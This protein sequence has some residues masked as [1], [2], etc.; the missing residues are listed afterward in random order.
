MKYHIDLLYINGPGVLGI[1]KAVSTSDFQPEIDNARK[2][3]ELHI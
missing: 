2:Q 3:P 1:V